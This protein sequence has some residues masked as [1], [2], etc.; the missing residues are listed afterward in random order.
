MTARIKENLL[1]QVLPL[2][3]GICHETFDG[4]TAM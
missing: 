1:D 2:P 4:V 3:V